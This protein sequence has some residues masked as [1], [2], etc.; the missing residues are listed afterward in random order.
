M[1]HSS[2]YQE[3]SKLCDLAASSNA[4]VVDNV[5]AEV[6]KIV[7]HLVRQW[8]K[9]HGLPEAL[10]RLEGGNTEMVSRANTYGC[11]HFISRCL[12]ALW[13]FSRRLLM[14]MG[15]PFRKLLSETPHLTLNVLGR[16]KCR[17]ALRLGTRG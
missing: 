9:D 10:R 6:L 14:V 8:W 1:L 3:L 4:S 13:Y 5:L 11:M 7:G 17:E 15:R 12:T 16:A 2:G